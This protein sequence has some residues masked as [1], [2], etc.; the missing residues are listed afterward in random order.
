MNDSNN[1]GEF[2]K[3]LRVS[4]GL[5]QMELAEYLNVSNKTVSKWESGVGLPEVTTLIVL[6]DFYDVTVDDILRGTKRVSKNTLKEANISNYV[7]SKIKSNYITVLIISIGIWLLSNVTIIILGEITNNSS[8]GMGVGIIIMVIGLIFQ[9]LNINHFR[10]QIKEIDLEPKNKLINLVFHTTFLY[11]YLSF[12]TF[13]FAGYYNIGPNF[14]LKLEFV[15]YNLI[16]I[17][18]LMLAS[19]II[20]YLLIRLFKFSFFNKTKLSFYINVGI[21]FLILTIPQILITASNSYDIAI[22]TENS[23]ISYSIYRKDDQPDR[24]YQLLYL[25]LVNNGKNTDEILNY[26]DVTYEFSYTFDDGYELIISNETFSLINSINYVKFDINDE[27][28]IA[29]M[30]DTSNVDLRNILIVT[31]TVPFLSLYLIGLSVYYFKTNNK[32]AKRSI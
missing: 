9:S 3:S 31:Y 1:T 4:K 2:L 20:I 24:Y 7:V 10:L 27:T 18:L 32:R 8:L 28:A 12:S 30:I 25:Q 5:T 11:I 15:L 22:K 16:Y 21:L 26:N 14:V 17:Y 29:Y 6:A 13:I 23:H 19:A